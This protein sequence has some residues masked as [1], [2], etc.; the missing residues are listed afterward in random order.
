MEIDPTVF[1]NGKQARGDDLAVS[2]DDDEVWGIALNKFLDI[3]GTDFFGL[4]DGEVGGESDFFCGGGRN[5]VAA[6]AWAVRLGDDGDDFEVG[7]REE[8]LEGGNGKLRRA[9]EKNAHLYASAAA[10]G[11]VAA[12]TTR[13]VSGVF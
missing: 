5:L 6:A 1:G 4:V 8:V 7:L 11:P 9:T 12:L 3:G 10:N 2:D 13:P